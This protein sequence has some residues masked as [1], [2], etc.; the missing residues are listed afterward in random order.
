MLKEILMVGL[1]GFAGSTLRYLVGRWLN[2]GFPWGTL[3][4][5][6]V[7]CFLIGLLYALAERGNLASPY[8]R[9]L[10]MTG[11]CGGFTTFS[12]FMNENLVMLRTG[13]LLPFALYTAG[14]ILAG[15]IA[16]WLGYLFIRAA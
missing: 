6:V 16:V 12:A 13:D 14:S 2:G 15:L 10:L 1:G 5:N 9:L 7:G 11:F 3:V 4:V 8:M